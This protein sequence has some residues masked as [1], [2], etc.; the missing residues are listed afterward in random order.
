MSILKSSV[1][2]QSDEFRAN[3]GLMTSLVADLREKVLKVNVY[4]FCCASK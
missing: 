4:T 2:P 3:A 1:R